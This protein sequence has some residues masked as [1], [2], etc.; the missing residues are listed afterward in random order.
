MLRAKTSQL[1]AT[2]NFMLV[3]LK[4]LPTGYNK[5]TQE[6]KPWLFNSINTVKESI[7][8]LKEI[9]DNLRLKEENLKEACKG[10]ILSLDIAEYLLKKNKSTDFRKMH[11]AIGNLINISLKEN[12]DFALLLK[13]EFNLKDEE[14]N[15]LLS[16][17]EALKRRSLTRGSPA[18]SQVDSMRK[19][20][21]ERINSLKSKL[22]ELNQ[23]LNEKKR[24]FEELINTFLT[25]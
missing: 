21:L 22:Q 18:P 8:I 14:L 2:S 23:R 11:E 19:K 9:L 25:P 24:R 1:I 17:D 5:D 7:T 20:R 13:E 15:K 3:L 10:F 16:P 4:G 6:L 12:K